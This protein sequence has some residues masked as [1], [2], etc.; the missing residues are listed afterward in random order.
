MKN[1]IF[2]YVLLIVNTMVAQKTI[3]KNLG[4]FSIL[5][6]YNGIELELIS[7]DAQKI[8][9]IG[10]KS[11]KVKIKNVNGTLKLSLKF[12]ELSA[13]GKVLIKLFYN[14]PIAVIDANEGATITGKMLKQ[15]KVTIKVQEK[16]FINLVIKVKELKVKSI[17]GGIIKLTGTTN[18]QEVSAN[19]YGVYHGF[20][21]EALGNSKVHAGTGAKVEVF[22]HKKLIAKVNFGGSIFYKGNPAVDKDKKIAG[23]VI[24]KRE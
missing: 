19:L 3:T 15:E 8:E 17:S 2:I 5:K 18:N 21:L 4:D 6:V 14:R 24:Q 9:I 10:E 22:T 1:N 11:E 7:S 16:A 12:P 23:G 13:N 20:S